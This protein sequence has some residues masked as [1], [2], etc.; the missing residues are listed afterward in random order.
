MQQKKIIKYLLTI[1]A[2]VI[3]AYNSIY[4]KKLD[5]VKASNFTGQFNAVSYTNKFWNKKLIPNLNK[6][7]EVN[8]LMALLQTDK[9]KA[10]NTCS[11]ALGIGNIRYFMI[12]GEGEVTGINENDITLL[13]TSDSARQA[14]KIATEYIF[15]NAVRDALGLMDINEFKNTMDFNNV[16]A[17][18]NKKIR[19]E[20]LPPF[21]T[22]V[23]KGSMVQFTGAIELNK[24]HLNLNDMEMI[25]V[26]LKVLNN[27]EAGP[28]NIQ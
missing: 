25:P 27:Q 24:E 11:H 15:G 5:E 17:E 28:G 14:V 21:K 3:V 9:E 19:T 13:S 6:A 12:K 20:V 4:F 7:I 22:A 18:I 16:S 1:V 23:K 8:Q 2:I 10:F 26:E